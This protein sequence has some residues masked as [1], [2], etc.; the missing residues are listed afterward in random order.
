M[1]VAGGPSLVKHRRQ[2]LELGE[3]DYQPVSDEA[4]FPVV[5]FDH[6]SAVSIG[7]APEWAFAGGR[8]VVWPD[9]TL[10]GDQTIN[11][12]GLP[13]VASVRGGLQGISGDP[14]G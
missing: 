7:A 1:A 12:S 10:Q 6:G 11:G 14:N 9:H 3:N 2:A 8:F 4:T 5:V 13:I